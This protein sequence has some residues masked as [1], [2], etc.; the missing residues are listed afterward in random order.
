MFKYIEM[1]GEI[2]YVLTH[3]LPICCEA[4]EV[5]TY[6]QQRAFQHHPRVWF[7]LVFFSFTI[8]S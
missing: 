8:H 1:V 6:Q 2:R 4:L 7:G 5:K 3:T